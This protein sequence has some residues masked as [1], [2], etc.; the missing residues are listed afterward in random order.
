MKLQCD[1]VEGYNHHRDQALKHPL[2]SIP[3]MLNLEENF[4][5]LKVQFLDVF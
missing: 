4:Y 3:R 2:E 1:H 5:A